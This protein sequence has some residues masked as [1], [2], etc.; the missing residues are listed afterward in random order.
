MTKI[1]SRIPRVCD[2]TTKTSN[3]NGVRLIKYSHSIVVVGDELMNQFTKVLCND[4]TFKTFGEIGLNESKEFKSNEEA[5][6][7]VNENL[8]NYGKLVIY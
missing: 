7:Y 6:S 8:S 3:E 4:N 5:Q 1:N 2:V